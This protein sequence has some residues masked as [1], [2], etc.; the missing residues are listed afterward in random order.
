MTDI[1]E[2]TI[3]RE[4]RKEE[5]QCINHTAIISI[6]NTP[7]QL[8]RSHFTPQMA[9]ESNMHKHNFHGSNNSNYAN[10]SSC[11]VK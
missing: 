6:N 11:I 2:H 9:W 10:K 1:T 8:V 5:K 7:A 4:K 3:I